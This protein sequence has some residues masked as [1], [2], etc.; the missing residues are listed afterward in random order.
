MGGSGASGGCS[1]RV[2]RGSRSTRR[3]ADGA[4]RRAGREHADLDGGGLMNARDRKLLMILAPLAAFALYWMVLLN[5]ALDRRRR[6]C[7]S[8]SSR[9]RPSATPPSRARQEV[10]SAKA[11]YKQDYREIVELSRA[12]PQSVARG[13]P[14]ARAQQG[15]RR[16]GD[17]VQQHHNGRCRAVGEPPVTPPRLRRPTPPT[18]RRRFRSQLTFT[19]GSSRLADSST[20]SSASSRWRTSDLADPRPADPDRRILV[21]QRVLP[22]HHRDRSARRSTPPRRRGPDRRRDRGRS[23]RCRAW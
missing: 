23:A 1:P 5:P 18:A 21:R 6:L 8:R 9:R 11:R 3:S 17:R 19:G 7:R 13:R 10:E 4:Q 15:R 2:A 22:R 16:H 12:I 20:A 14:D